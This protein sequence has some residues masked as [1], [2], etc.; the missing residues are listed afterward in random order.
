MAVSASYQ[1]SGTEP[2]SDSNL[3][4]RPGS[5]QQAEV[6]AFQNQQQASAIYARQGSAATQMRQTELE[7]AGGWQGAL[8]RLIV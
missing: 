5:A 3:S 4:M 1:K 6:A 7:R 8:E 2:P